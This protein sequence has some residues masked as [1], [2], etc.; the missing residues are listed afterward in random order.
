M[1]FPRWDLEATARWFSKSGYTGLAGQTWTIVEKNLGTPFPDLQNAKDQR[2]GHR[3][4]RLPEE[5]YVGDAFFIR[6]GY[7]ECGANFGGKAVTTHRVLHAHAM[8][9]DMKTRTPPPVE[10]TEGPGTWR[11]M[12]PPVTPRAKPGELGK[13]AFETF[14]ARVKDMRYKGVEMPFT[15]EEW[16]DLPPRL[17]AAFE[18]VEIAVRMHEGHLLTQ[19]MLGRPV[20]DDDPCGDGSEVGNG[21]GQGPTQA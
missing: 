20:H 16:D 10:I 17:R 4:I 8:H 1:G 14:Q 12:L 3:L 15:A 2:P 6:T 13:L 5:P 21:V 19:E 18:S 11:E 9:A 7:C